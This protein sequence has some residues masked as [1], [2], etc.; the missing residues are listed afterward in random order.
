[1]IDRQI[2]IYLGVSSQEYAKETHTHNG[3]NSRCYCKMKFSGVLS[4]MWNKLSR[5]FQC[6]IRMNRLKWA[7]RFVV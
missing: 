6:S 3:I 7:K 5:P 2:H 1:M 4:V